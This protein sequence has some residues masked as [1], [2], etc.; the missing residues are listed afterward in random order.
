MWVYQ[1]SVLNCITLIMSVPYNASIIAHERMDVF[2]YISML[3]ITMR[4]V[5][6]IMLSYLAYDK[7]ISYS[8]FEKDRHDFIYKYIF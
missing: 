1:I 3:D 4:L 5:A 7:L 6:V 2:A 8:L